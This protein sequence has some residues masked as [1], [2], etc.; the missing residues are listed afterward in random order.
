MS[1]AERQARWRAK[2]RAGDDV[3]TFLTL[4]RDQPQVDGASAR[5][6][7]AAH[8]LLERV[9]ARPAAEESI[10]TV[11]GWLGVGS[12]S[13]VGEAAVV[14]GQRAFL[15]TLIGQ[16][17]ETPSTAPAMS[18]RAGILIASRLRRKVLNVDREAVQHELALALSGAN[19][20][21]G[22]P[23]VAD[24]P[25]GCSQLPD[26]HVWSDH[27]N[28]ATSPWAKP[29]DTTIGR[30]LTTEDEFEVV[31]LGLDAIPAVTE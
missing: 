12:R 5:L 3:E 9:D 15:K 6:A 17:R 22:K 14:A 11:A 30:E 13:S 16:L 29:V 21:G 7:I 28:W 27:A 8:D 19:V 25:C 24:T 23:P 2:H 18:I 1:T 20:N 10:V 4:V 26:R 31:P